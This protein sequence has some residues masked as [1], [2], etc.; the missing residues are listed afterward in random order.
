MDEKSEG[1]RRGGSLVIPIILIL[2]GVLLLLDSLNIIPGVD[3]M[4]L[5]KFCSKNL[6]V[7]L[8]NAEK[9]AP[10]NG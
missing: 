6:A 5:L 4:T 2:F 1:R 10:S 8:A 7:A 9:T 3:W